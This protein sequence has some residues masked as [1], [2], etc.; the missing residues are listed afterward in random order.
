MTRVAAQYGAGRVDSFAVIAH[1]DGALY[2]LNPDEPIQL[3]PKETPWP[4]S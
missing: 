4:T 3:R 1:I 2:I